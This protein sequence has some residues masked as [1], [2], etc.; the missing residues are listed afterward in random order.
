MKFGSEDGNQQESMGH[1]NTK[2]DDSK[3]ISKSIGEY[4]D[5]EEVKKQE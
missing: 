1:Q 3:K 2:R 4:V 5:Y